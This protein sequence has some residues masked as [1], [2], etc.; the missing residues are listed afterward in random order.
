M[1]LS[2]KET[3][4]HIGNNDAIMVRNFLGCL[5]QNGGTL[6]YLND[7]VRNVITNLYTKLVKRQTFLLWSINLLF[8]LLHFCINLKLQVI[9]AYISLM[10]AEDH[11]KNRT[12]GK[13]FMETTFNSAILQQDGDKDPPIDESDKIETKSK[14]RMISLFTDH[15]MVNI[16][17]II[18][19]LLTSLYVST[20]FTL[21]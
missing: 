21:L 19:K 20:N 16:F 14:E 5:F 2:R 11:L 7:E 3:I 1:P 4:V 15:D 12:G 9:N 18:I 10:K 6:A 13:V 17:L 8:P